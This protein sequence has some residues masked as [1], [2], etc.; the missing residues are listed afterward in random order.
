MQSHPSKKNHTGTVRTWQ[1]IEGKEIFG[2]QQTMS[3]QSPSSIWRHKCSLYKNQ[4]A[5]S[6]GSNKPLMSMPTPGRRLGGEP[7][8]ATHA[9]LRE[10]LQGTCVFTSERAKMK[11]WPSAA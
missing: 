10:A 4:G 6:L 11:P 8:G 2:N 9:P 7:K 5:G 1:A 3:S